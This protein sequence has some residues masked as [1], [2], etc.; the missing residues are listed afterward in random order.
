MRT[1]A[2]GDRWPV[3]KQEVSGPPSVA[4]IVLCRLGSWQVPPTWT[5]DVSTG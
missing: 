2:A 3:S 5:F 4:G 1:I